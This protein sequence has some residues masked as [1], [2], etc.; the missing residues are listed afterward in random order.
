[1]PGMFHFRPT[2]LWALP[3][4]SARA[5]HSLLRGGRPPGYY[6]RARGPQPIEMVVQGGVMMR[7]KMQAPT[8]L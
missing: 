6:C 2:I 5:H 3:H 8:I 4:N 1:M 7:Q